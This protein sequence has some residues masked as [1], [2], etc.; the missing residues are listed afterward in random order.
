MSGLVEL[1]PVACASTP[2]FEELPRASIDRRPSLDR[3]PSIDPR[4]RLRSASATLHPSATSSVT[5]LRGLRGEGGGLFENTFY[6]RSNGR[7][8]LARRKIFAH[9]RPPDGKP[10]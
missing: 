10:R 9:A 1:R 4:R 2:A 6:F 5:P 8:V 7:I 3:H